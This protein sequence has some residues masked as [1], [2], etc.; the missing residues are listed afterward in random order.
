MSKDDF[1]AAIEVL[2]REARMLPLPLSL[3][4]ILANIELEDAY[5]AKR[6]SYA[7]LTTLD[8]ALR[9]VNEP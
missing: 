8:E 9:R 6:L 3:V 4:C 2:D 5:K 7:Q 1:L